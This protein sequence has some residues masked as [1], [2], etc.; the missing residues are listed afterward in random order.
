MENITSNTLQ[1]AE[2]LFE[3]VPEVRRPFRDAWIYMTDN[4]TKFQI[5]TW[6]SL[7]VHEV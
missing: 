2:Q 1:I 4:Y 7:I 3:Y 6:G 5:A